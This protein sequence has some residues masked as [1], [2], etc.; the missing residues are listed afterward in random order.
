MAT[1]SNAAATDACGTVVSF[2]IDAVSSGTLTKDGVAVIAGVTLLSIGETLL[3]T[4]AVNA[5]GV[6]TACTVTAWDGLLASSNAVG[7]QVSVAAA[8]NAPL[9][10]A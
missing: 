9:A 6:L 8:N 3:W 10:P 7:V 5:H 1:A 4:P 2:R